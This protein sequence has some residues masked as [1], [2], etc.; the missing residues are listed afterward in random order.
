VH[1]IRF[2][3]PDA[4][5]PDAYHTT[6]RVTTVPNVDAEP[7]RAFAAPRDLRVKFYEANAAGT[8]ECRADDFEAHLGNLGDGYQTE[9]LV[10]VQHDPPVLFILVTNADTS[11]D[12][13]YEISFGDFGENR[14]PTAADIDVTVRA[15]EDSVIIDPLFHQD[16]ENPVG[17]VFDLEIVSPDETGTTQFGVGTLELIPGTDAVH[18]MLRFTHDDNFFGTAEFTYTVQNEVGLTDT[19]TITVTRTEEPL[20]MDIEY[21]LQAEDYNIVDDEFHVDVDIDV[22]LNDIDPL[23]GEL[24]ILEEEL[25]EPGTGSVFVTENQEIN[26][27]AQLDLADVT[28]NTPFGTGFFFGDAFEYTIENQAGETSTAEVV[29][30]LDI[31][32]MM[33]SEDIFRPVPDGVVCDVHIDIGGGFAGTI[34][35]PDGTHQPFILPEAGGEWWT[36]DTLE[37]GEGIATSL[38]RDGLV[39]GW[40]LGGHDIVRPVRWSDGQEIQDL[41]GEDFTLHGGALD[42]NSDGQ[43]AG[44]VVDQ[45]GRSLAVIWHDD[46]MLLL[47]EMADG[48]DEQSIATRINDGNARTVIGMTGIPHGPDGPLDPDL[49]LC[50]LGGP[51]IDDLLQGGAGGFAIDF[52]DG[53]I[54]GHGV[55]T[56]L[57]TLG[58]DASIPLDLNDQGTI[59][60]VSMTEPGAEGVRK[61][62]A[63]L[64]QDGE[65]IELGTPG[66]E[67][68]YSEAR[69]INNQGVVVGLART[70]N[71]TSGFI[72]AEGEMVLLNDLLDDESDLNIIAAT[73]ITDNGEIVA[74]TETEEGQAQPILLRSGFDG[75]R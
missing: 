17:S 46:D 22:L 14:A 28:F 36:L 37:G 31:T 73:D 41:L 11:Y 58:G 21:N 74:W 12:A 4:L 6:V 30:R 33:D 54:P 67:Y 57:V 45:E 62:Q 2:P 5:T 59:V 3:I 23:D 29:I 26:Y 55:T 25:T 42:I 8:E 43:V 39:V 65:P 40:S 53:E 75:D 1:E 49:S 48:L 20:A 7:D 71:G 56:P 66:E 19:G 51:T 34:Q 70:V 27:S 32:P 18:D 72:W 69:A 64:W 9:H 10:D 13:E 16:T 50:N 15:D 68:F 24:I 44:Y 38:N 47:D 35:T 61:A 63:V 52:P 60:G